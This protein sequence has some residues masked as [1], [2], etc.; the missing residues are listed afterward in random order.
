MEGGVGASVSIDYGA[1]WSNISPKN[2]GIYVVW[3]GSVFVSVSYYGGIQYSSD[4]I[5][6]SSTAYPITV[7]DVRVGVAGATICVL[8]SDAS[9]GCC[10]STDG[11]NWT[12]GT[13]S[14]SVNFI[15]APVWNGSK[16]C[17]ITSN[18]TTGEA[19]SWTSTD[20]LSW[21]AS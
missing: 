10:T 11:V 2:Y 7:S 20:G 21:S 4:G 12:T 13:L 15:S 17:A 19:K 3:N 16:F 8:S 6:W 9:G 1:S 14:T 5:T 18:D